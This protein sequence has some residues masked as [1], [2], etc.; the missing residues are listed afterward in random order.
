MHI[1]LLILVLLLT[2]YDVNADWQKLDI[3]S[4]AWLRAVYFLNS[5][6]GFIVGSQGTLFETKDGGKTWRQRPKFTPDNILD[7]YFSDEKT[8]WL[9]CEPSLMPLPEG[10]KSYF[11]KTLDGGTTWQ[12]IE[13]MNE[14]RRFTRFFTTKNGI[15]VVG[16]AGALYFL[17]NNEQKRVNVP[18]PYRLTSGFAVNESIFI[19]GGN[20]SLLLFNQLTNTWDYPLLIEPP[21]N[22]LNAIFFINKQRGWLVGNEGKI[23]TTF[24][25]GK[26]WYQQNSVT[27]KNLNDVFYKN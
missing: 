6:H 9:L 10:P 1:I 23:Y 19:T 18:I 4:L 8:G 15:F 16:E 24:N 7:V 2:S 22:R 17:S 26:T 13:L 3:S 14:K 5:N 20:G 25:G 11:L 27:Y 12:K 21:K